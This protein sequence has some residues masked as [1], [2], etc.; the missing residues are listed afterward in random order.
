MNKFTKSIAAIMLIVAAIMVE[1]CNKSDEPNNGGND[2]SESPIIGLFSIN[3]STQV[4][5]SP[6]N[7]QYQAS[8]DTW[9]FAENQW[10]Y[11]G[12]DNTNVSET[13][14]GWIDLFAWGTGNKPTYTSTYSYDTAYN[15]FVDWGENPISNWNGDECQ[16][17]TLEFMDWYYLL[18]RRNT[19]SGV[20][21]VAA[22]VNDINGLILLP[23]NW[24]ESVFSLIDFN[25]NG[26]P[27]SSNVITKS[28]WET[29]ERCG[30]IFLPAA[31]VRTGTTVKW[32]QEA[33]LYWIAGPSDP[34]GYVYYVQCFG[35]TVGLPNY[36]PR[37]AGLSV[38]LV[39][40]AE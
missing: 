40:V 9:R 37:Y 1:G 31:G 21:Y 20:L 18:Y 30:A 19:D 26:C 32:V 6:G 11:I 23:D 13:Y 10:D 2:V 3:D 33:G 7:L 14:D 36:C 25:D 34:W 28:Q 24:D 29:M 38:R 8:T 22:T 5:F 35:G 12:E 16:W 15:T 4:C 17:R 39:R 27:F